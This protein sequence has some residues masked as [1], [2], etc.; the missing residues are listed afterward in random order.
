M[1]W[2]TTVPAS[3][4]LDLGTSRKLRMLSVPDDV[5]EKVRQVNPGFQ[6][7]VIPRATYAQYGVEEDV[8]TFQA[9]TILIAHART[10]A[11]V[12]YKVARA[13]VEGREDFGRVTSAMKGVSARDMAQSFGMPYHPGAE[14]YYREA[15][16][17]K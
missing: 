13:V 12:I 3:F 1:G 11:D 17:L 10:P 8:Q 2:F 5:I 7:Y 16:L 9:A 15:G 4:M 6:R 14:K